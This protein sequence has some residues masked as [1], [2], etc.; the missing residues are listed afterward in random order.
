MRLIACLSIALALTAKTEILW[1]KYGVPHIYATTTEEMFYAHG[2]AQMQN[3]ADLL[4][5][6]YGE[7]RGK[8]A[9]YWGES[10][11]AM[12]RWIHANGVPARAREW[13]NAQT[14][15]F[16]K[17]VDAFARG[18]NDHAKKHPNH[19][20]P[21]YRQVLPVS[22]V[23]VI[24]H[25]LRAVHY[26]YMGSMNRM[27]TEIAPL[28]AP[29]TRAALEQ[30]I[31]QPAADA[32]SNT[33]TV[34]PSRSASGKSM[35]IIN[36]HLAWEG[37]YSY[38]EVH[39]SGPKYNL[40]GAPQIGFPT[41]VIGF[42][43]HA[44][45]GRTVNT[46]DTV[47]FYKLTVKGNQY[48]FDGAWKDFTTTTAAIKVKQVDGSVKTEMLTTKHSVHGPVVYDSQGVTV[49]M[50]VAGIDRPKMLEQWYRM[51]GATNLAQFKEAMR[52]ISV[53]MWNANYADD[54]GHI[55]FVCNGTIP[56]RKTGDWE[57]YSKVLP[58]DSSNYLWTDYLKLEELPQSED[59]KSGFNQNANEQ[60]WHTTL[61]QI[62]PAKFNPTLAPPNSRPVTFRTKRSL[63]MISEDKSITYDE[64][65]GYKHNTRAEL[66]DAV[67]PDLLKGSPADPMAKRALEVLARWD[68]HLNADSRGAVLFQAFSDRYFGTGDFINARL[69]VP[70][71]PNDA[72]NSSYGIGDLP[73]AYEAL[74]LAA[75]DILK[76]YNMLDVPY[77]EVFRFERGA[78]DLPANGG[79]GRLGLFR[80]MT[81]AKR[82]GD[83]FYPTHGETW[84]CAIEF[85]T[86]QKANCLLGYGNASQPGSTHIDDQ[87]QHLADRKLRPIWRNRKDVEANLEK[88][89]SL[90]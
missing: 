81:F 16:R 82:V 34:G 53:P 44:G 43:E 25:T 15:E 14:P 39:L 71:N 38:M 19:V 29:K 30:A 54:Q 50:R 51:G 21:K 32:G 33:W 66:A 80:T 45:W 6:L 72:L 22:G 37:F 70:Y 4:L 55:Y 84:V 67:L 28:L 62:D 10:K 18:I 59:P 47:D 88:R 63:R 77:G 49:A 23:D 8:G 61:P 2:Y 74:R 13:Y 65:I 52:M 7:S 89:E 31:P 86:P 5:S 42:N 35:L 9:E 12:D 68:R 60:P 64:L 1:D 83:R 56:R 36:P 75:E 73:G 76:L 90:P 87:L 24:G 85:G 40:V 79:A 20:S 27:R 26:M 57:T 17:Y 58:G 3:Q 41:P 48:Q 11:L 46:I 78:K 69:R